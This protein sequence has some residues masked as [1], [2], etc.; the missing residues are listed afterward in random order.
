MR[1]FL[2]WLCEL[3]IEIL[4]TRLAGYR[5]DAAATD[6]IFRKLEIAMLCMCPNW[7]P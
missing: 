1:K 4:K 7:N 2:F 6:D 5:K 3:A